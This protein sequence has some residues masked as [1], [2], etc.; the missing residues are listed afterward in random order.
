MDVHRPGSNALELEPAGPSSPGGEPPRAPVD[1]PREQQKKPQRDL[2]MTTADE[3]LATAAREYEAGTVEQT[4]WRRAVDQCRSDPSLVIAAYLRARATELQLRHR[5]EDRSSG[6]PELRSKTGADHAGPD[7]KAP[8]KG[9]STF[10]AGA[11]GSVRRKVVWTA[12]ATAAL[13]SV[14][15][16]IYMMVLP[17]ERESAR[18]RTATVAKPAAQPTTSSA[19]AGEQP[20]VKGPGDGGQERP[21]P[22]YAATVKQLKDAG[23]WNVLVLYAAE[24]TRQEPNN[25]AAW[26]ELATGYARLRQY[27]EALDSAAKAV[28]LSPADASAWRSLGQINLAVD[29]LAEAGSAFDKALAV[30]PGDVDALCGTALVAQRQSRPTATDGAV[31]CPGLGNGEITVA[32]AGTSSVRRV[33]SSAGR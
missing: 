33:V 25:A 2:R 5:A 1:E 18:E 20:R 27:N 8:A 12:A 13:A 29:R 22:A 15:A 21:R 16:V 24:W 30:N 19:A 31:N 6:Q 17:A 14:V 32:P 26:R 28:Q 10:F 7:P 9:A 23:N 11:S 3:F 4:L